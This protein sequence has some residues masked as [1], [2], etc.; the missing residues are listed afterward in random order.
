[1][2]YE[3]FAGVYD[4]LNEDADY[5]AL[6]QAVLE[7]LH[8]AGIDSGIVADL[9]CGTGEL[10]LRLAQAGYDMIAVDLSE[11]MLAVLRE[12][13]EELP[14]YNILLLH[15]DMTALDLYGTARAVVSTFDTLNHIGPLERLQ[16]AI[17]RAAFFIERGGLC[18]F[19]MNT[20]YK[21]AQV[22]ADNT[23]TIEAE[24]G[25]CVWEN[26]YDPQASATEIT[27]RVSDESETFFCEQFTEF[28]YTQQQIET[29]CAAAGLSVQEVCDGETFA[30]L[31]ETSERFLFTTLKIC[32]PGTVPQ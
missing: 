5:D 10:T 21:H 1:M 29:A 6:A 17:T 22:L 2:A 16:T 7:R 4:L 23:F 15:Q 3:A 13:T 31:C 18:I 14:S 24:D 8:Q 30:P 12:K 32:E 28:S 25:V 20:P 27:L 9:G 11:D 19:D 26:R